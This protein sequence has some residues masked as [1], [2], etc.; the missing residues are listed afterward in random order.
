MK[1]NKITV[2]TAALRLLISRMRL[3]EFH[4]VWSCHDNAW[5]TISFVPDGLQKCLHKYNKTNRWHRRCYLRQG[6]VVTEDETRVTYVICDTKNHEIRHVQSDWTLASYGT[7]SSRGFQAQYDIV[8]LHEE[9]IEYVTH[10][11][12]M[13]RDTSGCISYF[14]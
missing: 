4:A 9:R 6:R 12:R 11:K 1:V 2:K 10:S 13:N 3:I 14:S 8:C 5:V 7:Q